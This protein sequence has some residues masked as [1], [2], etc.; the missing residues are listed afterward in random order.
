[1]YYYQVNS[2]YHYTQPN[3]N[4]IESKKNKGHYITNLKITNLKIGHRNRKQVFSNHPFLGA[5]LLLVSGM[6]FDF[7]LKMGPI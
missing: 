4:L 1:M 3:K 7:R 5:K 6:V 2:I